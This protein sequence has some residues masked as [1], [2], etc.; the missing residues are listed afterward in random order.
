MCTSQWGNNI[1]G[2][3]G[4]PGALH[5]MDFCC[6]CERQGG[7]PGASCVKVVGITAP[8]SHVVMRCAQGE[9]PRAQVS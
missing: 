1:L 2:N 6:L 4:D 3:N 7:C 9:R 8:N 5:G